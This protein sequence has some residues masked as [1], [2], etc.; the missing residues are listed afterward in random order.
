MNNRSARAT[1]NTYA[2]LAIR[3]IGILIS[4]VYVP[5]MLSI[6]DKA[7]YGILLTITTLIQ[8]SS[9][10]DVGL[11]NGLRNRLTESIAVNDIRRCKE[12]VS[13][14][15]GVMSIIAVVMMLLGIVVVP[16]LNWSTI[17]NAPES[18]SVELSNLML[19]IAILISCNFP[20][21]LITS[22]LYAVQLPALSS[23][24]AM[25]GQAVSF[26]TILLFVHLDVGLRMTGVG[27]ITSAA[28]VAVYIAAT[29]FIF[30]FRYRQFAP[31]LKYF[32]KRLISSVLSL[33]FNF[34]LLQIISLVL[35]Q[36]NSLIITH[37]VGNEWVTD[38]NIAYRYLNV[39]NMLFALVAVPYWSAS[40][41]AYARGEYDWIRNRIRNL[42]KI[43]LLAVILGGAMIALAPLGYRLWVGDTVSVDYVL[44]SLI[45]AY[46]AVN[47]GWV[48]WG[49]FINGIGAI[50]L[51]LWF[52]LGTAI[53]HVPLA[54]MF[55]NLWGIRGVALTM[56]IT[57][58]PNV[59]W[60]PIQVKK[61]LS[62]KAQGIW[63]K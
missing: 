11:G 12:L 42:S 47:M 44:L 63:I 58:L 16:Q 25:L 41:D 9:F 36:T 1:K 2:M 26:L 13:T 32:N 43:W 56:I 21:K 48:L 29:F 54:V 4:L 23:L 7:T 8:W 53:I 50:R 46:F 18:L 61:L 55:G 34:F 49:N 27:I 10:F 33:G 31:S 5:L 17:L 28:P 62:G 15:Y 24:V 57:L 52:T 45:L 51:Q 3:G 19:C 6:L 39:V 22:I 14:S 59:I 37:V 38:Y 60:A 30:R 20:L 40:T 35:F